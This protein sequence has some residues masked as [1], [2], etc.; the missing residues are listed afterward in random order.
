MSSRTCVI[1]VA[2]RLH[3]VVVDAPQ[4]AVGPQ[5]LSE[6]ERDW[7]YLRKV[8]AADPVLHRPS[9]RRPEL[10]RGNPRDDVGQLF[11]ELLLEHSV[12]PLARS[13]VLGDDDRLSEEVVGELDVQGQ[14]EP[15]RFGSRSIRIR[16]RLLGLSSQAL[17]SFLNTVMTGATVPLSQLATFDFDQEYPLVWRRGD[18][19]GG[20]EI[21]GLQAGSRIRI[22]SAW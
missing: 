8:G 7:A 9:D 3:P 6:L 11:G 22:R 16:A 13:H 12:N 20:Y 17:S 15:D 14:V 2:R 1:G 19:A 21:P 4:R 18:A 10:E 5:N